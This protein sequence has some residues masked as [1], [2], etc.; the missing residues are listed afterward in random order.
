MRPTSLLSYGNSRYG[1]GVSSQPEE[2][3]RAA[4]QLLVLS[5][6]CPGGSKL[7]RAQSG[8]TVI[9]GSL[10]VSSAGFGL[11]SHWVVGESVTPTSRV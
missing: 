4:L 8:E 10:R 1:P 3:R 7:L 2:P 11:R 6:N 9:L 5:E